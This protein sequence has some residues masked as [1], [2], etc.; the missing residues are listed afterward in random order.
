MKRRVWVYQENKWALINDREHF[1][2]YYMRKINLNF[3]QHGALSQMWLLYLCSNKCQYSPDKT[4]SRSYSGLNKLIQVHDMTVGTRQ[5]SA[6]SVGNTNSTEQYCLRAW[7]LHQEKTRE[8]LVLT[9][10]IPFPRVCARN[11]NDSG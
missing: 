6:K 8:D 1:H 11:I 7:A 3:K 5:Y 4:K 10:L 2:V 9:H